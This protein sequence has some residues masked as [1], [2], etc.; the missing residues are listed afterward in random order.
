M[1]LDSQRRG[2]ELFI[3]IVSDIEVSTITCSLHGFRHV[4][5]C[6]TERP[7]ATHRLFRSSN[8]LKGAVFEQAIR[9]STES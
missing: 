4:E 7:Y 6:S 1:K 2:K 3:V 8:T 5:V 9:K